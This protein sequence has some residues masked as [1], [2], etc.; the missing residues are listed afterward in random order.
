MSNPA[1]IET[2]DVRKTY[3]LEKTSI[4][5]LRGVSL[6]IHAGETVSIMGASGSGKST[7]MHLLG[8]LDRP[9][10]G[11]VFF[12]GEDLT[13]LS[14]AKCTELRA[15][16]IGFVFQ[17]YHLLPEL[18]ITEN[19]MLPAMSRAGAFLRRAELES[20]AKE[21]L[22]RVGLSHRTAHRPLELSGGEQ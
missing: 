12:E 17:A 7:L 8:G 1:L 4:E 22:D 5:V 9:T 11:Q 3:K 14:T 16:A 6:S 18:S 15:T 2:R 10:A 19:V 21:L 20:R 13:K